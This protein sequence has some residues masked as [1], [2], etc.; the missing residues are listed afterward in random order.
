MSK[1]TELELLADLEKISYQDRYHCKTTYDVFCHAAD[2]YPADI[3]IAEHVTA[4][5]DEVAKEITFA[6]LFNKL[7]QTANLYKKFGVGRTDVVSILLPNLTE[8]HLS[9]WAAQAVGIANPV[10]YLLQ[11]DHIIEI[12]NEVKTKVLV[13]VSIDEGTELGK[14][15]HEIIA[16]VP[17]L[18]HI[19]ILDNNHGET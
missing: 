15:V 1:L 7:N 3:A 14:K 9:M 18:E 6:T 16:R 17:S 5:R 10:N 4:T 13:T 12:L 19:L 2:E 8:T 11:V